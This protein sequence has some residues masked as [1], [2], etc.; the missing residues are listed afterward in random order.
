MPRTTKDAPG[1]VTPK[2]GP[3]KRGR[4][5]GSGA[6]GGSGGTGGG[7]APASGRYTPP[8]PREFR[9][10]SW[11]VPALILAFMGLGILVILLN[12][13]GL[14]GGHASNWYLLIGLGLIVAGFI[15][16]TRWH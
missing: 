14:L 13:L 6:T 5:G 1:R 11:W 8:I 2:G 12:Y 4:P 7:T 3:A 16:A 15:T 10:S 9:T